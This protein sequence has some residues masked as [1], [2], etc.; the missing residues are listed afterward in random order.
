M[1]TSLPPALLN[2]TVVVTVLLAFAVIVSLPAPAA[3]VT[4]PKPVPSAISPTAAL[5]SI[6]SAPLPPRMECTEEV[7]TIVKAVVRLC[8]SITVVAASARAEAP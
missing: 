1:I 5:A 2:T 6:L 7:A 4:V 8:A 3:I